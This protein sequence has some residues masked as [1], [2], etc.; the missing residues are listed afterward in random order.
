MLRHP[1]PLPAL[2]LLVLASCSTAAPKPEA[3]TV[4]KP[5]ARH[6]IETAPGDRN[7]R[8]DPYLNQIAQLIERHR[9]VPKAASKTG[10][11]LEGIVVYSIIIDPRGNLRSLTLTRSSGSPVLDDAGERMLRETA[12][13]PPPPPSYVL[14]WTIVWTADLYSEVP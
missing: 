1:R 14:D 7:L 13:F 2:L 6:V 12:P 11:P 9:I 5:E 3:T 4:P 8:S 10:Q